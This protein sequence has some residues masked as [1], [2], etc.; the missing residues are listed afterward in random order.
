MEILAGCASVCA[1]D[2]L[3][4]S[5]VVVC[6]TL[7]FW[8][9]SAFPANAS[10]AV[11]ARAS[12]A[13]L[14]IVFI[15]LPS[16]FEIRK[17]LPLDAGCPE[18]LSLI[19]GVDQLSEEL[20]M[21]TAVAGQLDPIDRV[22]VARR[23]LDPEARQQER[24]RLVEM[25]RGLQDA[26]TSRV[27]AGLLQGV[28]HRVGDRHPVVVENVLRL[29]AGE[30][31]PEDRLVEPDG[32]VL[33]PLLGGR[34]LYEG[35]RDRP[36]D[37]LAAG[38]DPRDF[39]DVRRDR[40]RR[41]VDVRVPTE[42]ERADV[43]EDRELRRGEQH[44][45]VRAGA[46]EPCHLRGDA[47]VCDLVGLRAD[48]LR[49]AA[50]TATQAVEHV[51]AEVGVLV[52]HGDPRLRLIRSD[53]AAVDRPLARE[54]REV[55]HRKRVLRMLGGELRYAAT[56]EELRHLAVVEVRADRERVLG[57]DAVEDGQHF[58]LFDE[59]ARQGDRLRDVELVVEILVVDLAP[60]D[61]A[62]RVDIL[63]VRVR[64]PTDRAVGG[65]GA[66]DG[67]CPADRD[68]ARR[69]TGRRRGSAERDR[70]R[71]RGELRDHFEIVFGSSGSVTVTLPT[72]SRES[73]GT[74]LR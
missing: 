18:E 28:H 31:T 53:V 62:F 43:A 69:D 30:E 23:G 49:L 57:A 47:G 14:R 3:I 27:A 2:A 52:Q 48:D 51:L 20:P 55:Y 63:E 66:A 41:D 24:I 40:D 54:A 67:D 46:L 70:G 45:R 50:E 35:D 26:R 22:V 61:A 44:E 39:H 25:G 6:L 74:S 42:S 37:L 17:S 15:P 34:I 58:V 7:S 64:T 21:I 65:G 13:S 32:L 4:V 5:D 71:R 73:S 68:R 1:C 12:T 59:L 72:V 38:C 60:E 11:P 29:R 33:R 16:Y 8:V 36:L 19:P 9:A 10:T 56:E